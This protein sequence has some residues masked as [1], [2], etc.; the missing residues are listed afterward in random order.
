MQKCMKRNVLFRIFGYININNQT[1]LL[2]TTFQKKKINSQTYTFVYMSLT[3]GYLYDAA[4]L[5]NNPDYA[6]NKHLIEN[7]S[8]QRE[9]LISFLSVN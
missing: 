3:Y 5:S 6:N 9:R 2:Y 1:N 7:E 4:I 8:Q